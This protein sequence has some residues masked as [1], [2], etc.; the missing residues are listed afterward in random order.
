MACG[1]LLMIQLSN[2]DVI[3]DTYPMVR[4]NTKHFIFMEHLALHK[5][6]GPLGCLSLTVFKRPENYT[7]VV[8]MLSNH[9]HKL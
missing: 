3:V 4:I 5:P 2:T 7:I 9:T 1:K 8:I 6:T